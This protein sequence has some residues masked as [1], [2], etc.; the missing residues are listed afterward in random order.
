VEVA[1]LGDDRVAMRDSKR[2]G[3]V[4]LVFSSD[5]WVG[6]LAWVKEKHKDC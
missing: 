1:H 2:V 5:D 3:N 6:F 4:P